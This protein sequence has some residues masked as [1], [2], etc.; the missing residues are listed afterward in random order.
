MGQLSDS[1]C[2]LKTSGMKLQLLRAYCLMSSNTVS[3]IRLGSMSQWCFIFCA[4]NSVQLFFPSTTMR[5]LISG[6]PQEE[7]IPSCS[8]K[9]DDWESDVHS[10]RTPLLNTSN[11]RVGQRGSRINETHPSSWTT[12]NRL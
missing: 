4:T 9:E 1:M 3:Q 8:Y 2:G 5:C 10:G 6:P 7:P 12:H 11:R